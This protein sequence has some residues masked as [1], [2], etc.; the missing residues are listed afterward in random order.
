MNENNDLSENRD[1]EYLTLAVVRMRMYSASVIDLNTEAIRS[2]PKRRGLHE[3]H[4]NWQE[5]Q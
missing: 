2:F 1:R 4:R 5:L 3:A